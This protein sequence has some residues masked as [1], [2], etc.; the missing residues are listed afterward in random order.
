MRGQNKSVEFT[1]E[2]TLISRDATVFSVHL[3]NGKQLTNGLTGVIEGGG[4]GVTG[5]NAATNIYN[6]GRIT[7]STGP[8]IHLHAGGALLNA[9]GALI[10]GGTEGVFLINSSDTVVNSGTISATNGT[11][12]RL[13]GGSVR[14]RNETSGTIT[15]TA[16]GVTMV[17]GS[18][19][20][21]N[22]GTITASDANGIG[23]RFSSGGTLENIDG[24]LIQ[25]GSG[26]IQTTNGSAHITSSGTIAGGDY[27]VDFTTGNGVL[28]LQT[29]SLLQ[30]EARG[31][32]TSALILQGHG[33]AS[34]PFLAFGSLDMTGTTWALLNRTEAKVSQ[35]SQGTLLIGLPGVTGA[36]LITDTTTV[37]SGTALVGYNSL[38]TGAV[39]NQGLLYVGNS[40]GFAGGK[41]A[42][43]SLTINGS[44]SNAGQTI[45]S[46]GPAFGNQLLINGD[47]IGSGGR[48][49]L[50]ALLADANLGPLANQVADRMLVQGNAS[51][52]LTVL[53]VETSSGIE[54]AIS[55][56]NAATLR[57]GTTTSGEVVAIGPD[58][59][60]SVIQVSGTATETA[61]RLNR[62]YVN[63]GTPYK[64]GLFAF[65]PGSSNGAAATDQNLV[66]NASGYWDYRLERM[67]VVTPPE[68][69][70]DDN[71]GTGGNGD[72]GGNGGTGGSGGGGRPAVVPQ[73]PGYLVT[74]T[75]L[76]NATVQ[77]LD[78]LH[79]RL[80]E[81]RDTPIP[82]DGHR[83]TE[84]F[85]RVYGGSFDYDTPIAAK[86]FGYQT[87]HRYTALQLGVH[88]YTRHAEQGS[89]RLGGALTI[90]RSRIEPDALDGQSVTHVDT[91]S[92]AAIA[93]YQ[94]RDGWYADGIVSV[95]HLRG[96]TTTAVHDGNVAT[97]KGTSLAASVEM[98]YP[99]RLGHSGWNLEPQGQLVWNKLDFKDFSDADQVQ[100]HLGNP[101]QSLLRLGV[102]LVKPAAEAA[103]RKTTPYLKANYFHGLSGNR[104]A[105]L[106]GDTFAVGKY[107]RAWSLGAGIT[108]T[109]NKRMSFYTDVAYQ[110]SISSK[111]WNGWQLNGGM[112][113]LFDS[114]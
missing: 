74:P 101:S 6:Y 99:L 3:Q 41:A 79:R 42:V 5:I 66:G 114:Y 28:T 75:A 86:D 93:T 67:Y 59:G 88:A 64:F 102:R 69:G 49:Q 2:G 22:A 38:I 76:F 94:H 109:R 89:L 113:Y 105:S 18:E 11:G 65:G 30:G 23:V 77:D 104:E 50:G 53:N 106:S 87:D 10:Q 33:T 70:G 98:G 20:V 54:R 25:G 56:G 73:V 103:D 97:I 9:S 112:R 43:S 80:G 78:S 12:L 29:G 16:Y 71:S 14:V 34:N 62:G 24:A 1:N 81:V 90:G 68:G 100:V 26:G 40:Y 35:V 83:N 44:L 111:G 31:G 61:F 17:N 45:L 110:Q 82:A 96:K 91:Q 107:G 48:L 51:G 13:E 46:T 57:R 52:A 27:S 19:A 21:I 84:V 32:N 36:S 8:G 39:N 4:G 63:G 85:A 95:G 60:V 92:I 47:Y 72:T 7:A 108:G 37:H 55:S 15:G 58:Q